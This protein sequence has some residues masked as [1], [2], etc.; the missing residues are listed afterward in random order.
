[1]SVLLML[2]PTLALMSDL[3]TIAAPADI[4]DLPEPMTSFGATRFASGVALYGGATGDAHSYDNTQQADT[5]YLLDNDEWVA[6]ANGEHLQGNALV[7]VGDKIVLL[8]GFTAKNDPGEDQDLHSLAD[9]RAFRA[10]GRSREL[11]P[12]PEPRSSFDAAV[13]EGIIYVVGG[14]ALQ[15]GTE[16]EWHQT[17]WRLDPAA[18]SPE[19]E[20]LPQPPFQRRALATVVHDGTLYAL[21]GMHPEDGPSARVDT[22]DIAAGVWGRGPDIPGPPMAGFGTAGA[23][24]GGALHI[25][26]MQGTVLRLDGDAWTPVGRLNRPR[27]FHRIVPTG[28]RTGLLIGGT[29]MEDGK[30]VAVDRLTLPE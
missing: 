4:A 18:D 1:M 30:Y 28:E 20:P 26:T 25:T 16:T 11:P 17:A 13:H 14:W 24:L 22:Y 2:A 19:W 5:L 3:P 29:A 7:S 6:V 8:G 23:V 15:G 21:G 12:L 9:V 10:D 27:Y